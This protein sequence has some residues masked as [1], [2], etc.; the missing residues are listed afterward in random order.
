MTGGHF[1]FGEDLINRR[2]QKLSIGIICV[3]LAITVPD[4]M[5]GFLRNIITSVEL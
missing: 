3:L 5:T 1:T 2:I 4:T